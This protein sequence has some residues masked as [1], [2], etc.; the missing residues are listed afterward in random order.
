MVMLHK[1]TADDAGARLDN[2]L[3]AKLDMSRSQVKRA[4]DEG[5]VAVNGETVKAGYKLQTNDEISF[6]EEAPYV[7][8]PKDVAFQVLY[9]D[10]H[11]ACIDKP[12]GLVIHPGAGREEETLVHGLMQRFDH[13]AKGSDPLRPGIVHRLD[14]DTSGVMVV[15]KTDAAYEG[16][17]EAFQNRQVE[18]IYYAICRGV[19]REAGTIDSPI[20]RD[21]KNRIRMAAG[22]YPSKEALTAYAPALAFRD[23]TLIRVA[24]HTGRTHQ[25]RVHMA[26]VGHALLGDPLYGAKN[27]KEKELLLHS[28][29]LAFTHPIT[30]EKVAVTSK[31]PER[32]LA[33]IRKEK[34]DRCTRF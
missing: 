34:G 18:K 21:P 12:Y 5:R 19:I 24:L 20:G 1:F 9:E 16:L 17:L 3:A 7:L 31:L 4:V 8:V 11:L 10:A 6:E 23:S 15:A 32:M 27:D 33:Y 13:L 28:Y 22:V 25:I 14:K 26:S 2:F 30:G 29:R